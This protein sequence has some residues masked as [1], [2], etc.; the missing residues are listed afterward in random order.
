M[1]TTGECSTG[2]TGQTTPLTQKVFRG[3]R[4]KWK[5]NRCCYT[6]EVFL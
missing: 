6:E 1:D 4:R 5:E 3:E 2:N